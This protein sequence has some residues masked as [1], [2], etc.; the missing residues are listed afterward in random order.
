M[1]TK[2]GLYNTLDPAP[3]TCTGWVR[4]GWQGRCTTR[5]SLRELQP[6]YGCFCFVLG[7]HY[8]WRSSKII[9]AVWSTLTTHEGMVVSR[10][11]GMVRRSRGTC[12]AHPLLSPG[13]ATQKNKYFSFMLSSMCKKVRLNSG[14]L[15]QRAAHPSCD[16][17]NTSRSFALGASDVCLDGEN[18]TYSVP[19]L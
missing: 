7:G 3:P 6:R 2:A 12:I 10:G 15:Y 5:Q 4:V 18:P 17:P 9:S 14:V 1:T 11:A 13:V 8:S 19:A 16:S